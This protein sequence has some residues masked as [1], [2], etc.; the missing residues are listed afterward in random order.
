MTNNIAI[1]SP[2][3]SVVKDGRHFLLYT[4]HKTSLSSGRIVCWPIHD[5]IWKASEE[6]RVGEGEWVV[7][8]GDALLRRPE[9]RQRGGRAR[10]RPSVMAKQV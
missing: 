3:E 9:R 5:D 2:I 6:L 4:P 8:H 1:N 7:P 10:D